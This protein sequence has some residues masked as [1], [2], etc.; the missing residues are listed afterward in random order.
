[1]SILETFHSLRMGPD[2]SSAEISDIYIYSNQGTKNRY[3]TNS[4]NGLFGML[5]SWLTLR[6]SRPSIN[7]EHWIE[8]HHHRIR[9]VHWHWPINWHQEYNLM[10][11]KENTRLKAGQNL[12]PNFYFCW[13]WALD[14]IVSQSPIIGISIFLFNLQG[15]PVSCV[16]YPEQHK[17]TCHGSCC[18]A[19]AF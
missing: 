10:F 18:T 17:K 7:C 5:I 9:L 6:V 1:M 2:T 19:S 13:T 4:E 8:H 16:P 15:N 11:S 3:W 12:D 14:L